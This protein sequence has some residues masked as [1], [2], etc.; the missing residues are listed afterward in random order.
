VEDR[1]F[2]CPACG[3]DKLGEA[4]WTDPDAIGGGSNEI[5]P[6]CKIQFGYDDAAGGDPVKRR[7]IWREWVG[8]VRQREILCRVQ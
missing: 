7:T 1:R 3:Y 4:A 5:C 6:N 8:S 2:V